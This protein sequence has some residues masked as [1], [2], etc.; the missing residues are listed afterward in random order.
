M[1]NLETE[2]AS[3]LKE[4]QSQLV[5]SDLY[6]KYTQTARALRY[7]LHHGQLKFDNSA[8]QSF[9]KEVIY[10]VMEESLAYIASLCQGLF[11][12]TNH[13]LRALLELYAII[14][15]IL[16]DAGKKQKFLKRFHLFPSIAFHKVLHQHDDAF[17]KL[18]KDICKEFFSEYGELN[19]EILDVFNVKSQEKLLKL[20]TWRGNMQISN[21]F[22]MCPKPEIIKSD[23]AK[24]CLFTHISS[25][26][27]RSETEAYPNFCKTKETMLFVATRYAAFGYAC[28]KQHTLLNP[29]LQDKLDDIF[30]PLVDA[31]IKAHA[32]RGVLPIPTR[33]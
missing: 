16:S 19:S 7:T 1:I 18:S 2:E 5:Q 26:C 14:E 21:L 17:L 28:I 30:D 22:E 13:N 12:S 25:V 8:E 20:R 4:L 27:R 10:R 29:V 11:F 9:A 3:Y 33:D 15:H 32:D 31:L 23:Y 24:L 6:L